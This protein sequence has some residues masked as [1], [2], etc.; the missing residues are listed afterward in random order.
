MKGAKIKLMLGIVLLV[1]GGF[2]VPAGFLIP[3][4][5]TPNE[6]VIFESPGQAKLNVE[7]PGRF[8]LWHNYR[9]IQDGRQVVRN[10]HLPNGMTFEV[11][12]ADD[13][14]TL[15][16]EPRSSMTTEMGGSASRSIG[17]VDVESPG[18]FRIAVRGGDDQTRI[19]SFSRSRFMIFL[20]AIGFS[21]L[22]LAVLGSAGMV[23][24]IIGIVQRS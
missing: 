24:L 18:E 2:A 22:S 1:V 19:M 5:N 7:A 10:K 8:Y 12:R 6:E 20:R 15:T 17:Y 11:I 9:T 4:F 14:S 16:F 21:V 23:L 3:A 13:G